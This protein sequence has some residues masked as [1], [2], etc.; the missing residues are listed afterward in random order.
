MTKKFT[1]VAI[2]KG[3]TEGNQNATYYDEDGNVITCEVVTNNYTLVVSDELLE[4]IDA[5]ELRNSFDIRKRV[6]FNI[7]YKRNKG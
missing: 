1:A 7:I 2:V 4:Y 3:L 6:L 5:V